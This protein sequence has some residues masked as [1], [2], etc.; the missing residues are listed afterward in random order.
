M[1]FIIRRASAEDVEDMVRNRIDFQYELGGHP[2][3][4]FTEITRSYLKR[5]MDDDS[6]LCYIA[7]WDGRIISSVIICL[8]HVIPTM[9]NTAGSVGYVFNVFTRKDFRRQGLATIL[10]RFGIEDAK[11]RGVGELFLE[12][13]D[14]GK[15][16]YQSLGFSLLQREMHL[17]LKNYQSEHE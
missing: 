15:G 1:E 7:I 17:D 14:A 8:Y 12:A 3:D 2:D 5:H 6:M 11:A 4:E 9:L 16:V 13:Q 10:L